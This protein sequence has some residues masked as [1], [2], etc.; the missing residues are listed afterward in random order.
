MLQSLFEAQEDIRVYLGD[1]LGERLHAVVCDDSIAARSAIEF[2]EA[3]G[4]GRCRFLVLS[5]LPESIPERSYP[6]A[7]KPLLS[8]MNFDSR[9]ERLIHFLLAE[10]YAL[11]P[12]VFSDH[13]VCGGAAPSEG[14]GLSLTDMS[15]LKPELETLGVRK[16][17]VQ[18]LRIAASSSIQEMESRVQSIGKNLTDHLGRQ[19]AF[20]AQLSE[21][22]SVSSA[23]MQNS[24]IVESEALDGLKDWARLA[25]EVVDLQK[26][27][28]ALVTIEIEARKS[29]EEFSK[30]FTALKEKLVEEKAKQG[31]VRARLEAL[32]GQAANLKSSSERFEREKQGYDESILRARASSLA[33]SLKGEECVS[34]AVQARQ[35]LAGLYRDLALFENKSKT[36]MDQLRQLEFDIHRREETLRLMKEGAAFFQEELHKLDVSASASRSAEGGLKTRLWD[37]WQITYEEA[38]SKYSE[39][40]VNPERLDFLR[41]R[42]NSL[43]HVNMAAPEEYEALTEKQAFLTSQIADITSAR[44]DLKRAIQTINDSTRENFRNTFSEIREEF[45]KL[46]GILFEGGEA[47]LVLSE[48]ENILE[49]GIEIMA[50]PPGKRLQSLSLLSGGEKALTAIALLFAFFMVRPSPFC[51]LDEA[52]A[53]LDD[54]NVERFVDLL[55][56]FEHRTQFLIASHN[57]RTI[58][59]ASAIYGVTMEEMGISQLI[60]VDFK[61][62]DRPVNALPSPE[63]NTTSPL[64]EVS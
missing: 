55:K 47:D 37:Q 38:K 2:L 41:K 50:Q 23:R 59:A 35:E 18:A 9:N 61:S 40:E 11:G 58:E 49:T 29:Q 42:L 52:D 22:E 39:Q 54:A 4:R 64:L 26:S 53:A 28:A 33:L 62:K 17:E 5:S 1:I 20:Q 63:T 16:E 48:P 7:A 3:S 60:S 21:K 51:M 15:R 12:A 43:G 27:L 56:A 57:K 46:Y 19:Q 14:E 36:A 8:K 34:K 32:E 6:D 45:R 10:S 31:T 13:W 25:E 30:N 44:D 24:L